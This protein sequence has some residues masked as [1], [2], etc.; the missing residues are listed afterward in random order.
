MFEFNS[1]GVHS[2]PLNQSG[3]PW[4]P[5]HQTLMKFGR[6]YEHKSPFQEGSQQVFRC[7]L[8]NRSLTLLTVKTKSVACML[9][10]MSTKTFNWLVSNPKPFDPIMDCDVPM[11]MDLIFN[12]EA[13]SK[14]GAFK[15][16]MFAHT[17][18]LL[19]GDL[20]NVCIKQCWYMCPVSR[21]RLLYDNHTQVTK[22]SLEI[23]C[24]R[25]GSALMKLV[26]DFIAEQCASSFRNSIDTLCPYCIGNH[27]KHQLR[28][29]Y[30]GRSH[31]WGRGWRVCEIYWKWLHNAVLPSSKGSC[32]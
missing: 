8:H 2:Q 4:V 28:Y 22:L 20:T 10:P 3:Q 24:L 12:P 5:P 1:K 30:G 16:A 25:W 31:W 17:C 13:S 32:T 26:Y 7:S 15:K 29:V 27:W 23:N 11:R 9:Y 19:L 21:T 14:F 6:H 18:Q